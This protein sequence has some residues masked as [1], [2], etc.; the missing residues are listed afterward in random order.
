MMS[1]RNLDTPAIEGVPTTEGSPYTVEN[2]SFVDNRLELA[3]IQDTTNTVEHSLIGKI[4]ALRSFNSMLI[5]EMVSKAWNLKGSIKTNIVGKNLF[6][7]SFENTED[8]HYAY[9]RHPWTIKGAHLILREWKPHLSWDEYDFT[10]SALWTQVHGLPAAWLSEE[11]LKRIGKKVGKVIE[12]EFKEGGLIQHQRFTRLRVEVD[13]TRPLMPG[14][15]LPR[16]GLNDLWIS[17]KYEKLPEFCFR[18][19]VIGHDYRFC[20]STQTKLTNQFGMKFNAFGRWLRSESNL[21]P[22]GVYEKPPNPEESYLDEDSTES[23]LDPEMADK[24]N[25][26][27]KGKD[28]KTSTRQNEVEQPAGVVNLAKMMEVTLHANSSE[29]VIDTKQETNPTTLPDKPLA[30]PNFSKLSHT[31][32][33]EPSK[34]NATHDSTPTNITSVNPKPSPLPQTENN[35][36]QTPLP[37]PSQDQPMSSP[38]KPSTILQYSPT[39]EN[40]NQVSSHRTSRLKKP[41][42]K[43]RSRSTSNKTSSDHESQPPVTRKCKKEIQHQTSPSVFEPHVSKIRRIDVAP[44]FD[45]VAAAEQPC[46]SQ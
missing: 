20:G 3:P 32:K 46:Q 27:Q 21:T 15:F 12:S 26:S 9:S 29:T 18:C 11:S 10:T 34:D 22:T 43:L 36:A 2:Q 38:I 16:P 45:S 42:W 39:S 6:T 4:L 1:G 19:G 33:L 41:S 13:I 25:L 30:Y 28:N 44:V 23:Q 37:S 7:F 31:H 14:F 5:Q 17:M 8:L 35:P 24:T 40:P